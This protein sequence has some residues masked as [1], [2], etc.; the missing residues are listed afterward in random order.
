[1]KIV[2]GQTSGYTG[3]G[4]F[5]DSYGQKCIIQPSSSA[6]EAKIHLG[7]RDPGPHLDRAG[8]MH[9]TRSMVAALLPYLQAFVDTGSLTTIETDVER[10]HRVEAREAMANALAQA[11]ADLSET[12]PDLAAAFQQLADT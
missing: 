10:A 5:T 3:R 7:V 6:D 12:H 2:F 9:L 1:M 8:S 4:E 11:A